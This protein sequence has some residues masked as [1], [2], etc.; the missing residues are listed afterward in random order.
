MS[1]PVSIVV[2]IGSGGNWCFEH[3]IGIAKPKLQL[4]PH[5]AQQR[6]IY[7]ESPLYFI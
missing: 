6:D 5:L 3:S 7:L 4:Q 1:D 2:Q